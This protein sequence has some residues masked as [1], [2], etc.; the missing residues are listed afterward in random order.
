MFRILLCLGNIVL[1]NIEVVL[2]LDCL[3]VRKIY[4][5]INWILVKNIMGE[6]SKEMLRKIFMFCWVLNEKEIG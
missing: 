1:N 5:L 6:Y 4:W 3:L 2:F